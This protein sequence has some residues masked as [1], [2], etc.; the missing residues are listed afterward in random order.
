M[1]QAGERVGAIY[2]QGDGVV[3]LFGYGVYEGDFPFG[4]TK[5]TDPAGW[6]ADMARTAGPLANPRIRLDSGQ[7]VWGCEC[8]W[9]LE[10]RIKQVCGAAREVRPVDIDQTRAEVRAANSK[11]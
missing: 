3:E 9:G 8:W 11:E 5:T 2:G 6:V 7:I 10:D 1:A 4:D